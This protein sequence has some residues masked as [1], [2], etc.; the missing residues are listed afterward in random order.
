VPPAIGFVALVG[1]WEWWV[2]AHH[3]DAFVMPTPGRIAKAGWHDAGLLRPDLLATLE[4]GLAGLVLGAVGGVALALVVHR[5]RLVRQILM[6]LLVITQTVPTVVLAPLFTI[7]WGFTT[8]PRLVMVFLITVFP[9]L[10]STLGGL[11]TTDPDLIDLVRS[12]GASER[13]VARTVRL[14][15]ARPAFFDGL[16]VAATY[17]LGGEV[18]AE[19]L[20]GA[21]NPHGLGYRIIAAKRSYQIDRIFVA[22]VAIGVLTALLFVAI[23]ALA[24]VAIPWL[25]PSTLHTVQKG[26]S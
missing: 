5:V 14:P 6:P 22:V 11:D 25:R 16:R 12:T 21:E 19:Y 15:S 17:A 1:A 3:V 10:V 24:R 2:A 26:S 9:V 8:T 18:I 7:W 23:D 20:G 4:V 13:Q